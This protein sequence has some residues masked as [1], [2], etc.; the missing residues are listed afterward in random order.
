MAEPE[1]PLLHLI[2]GLE[3]AGLRAPAAIFLDL[4]SPVDVI[5][6]QLVCFG[7]PFVLGTGAETLFNRLGE[8][9]AWAELRRLLA[10]HD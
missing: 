2:A 4:L 1:E 3:R 5:T 9:P 10:T 7:R 8:P 6:S